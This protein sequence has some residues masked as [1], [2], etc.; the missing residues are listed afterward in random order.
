MYMWPKGTEK[1][2][3][4]V[5]SHVCGQGVRR[6]C[7]CE[8][9]RQSSKMSPASIHQQKTMTAPRGGVQ[10]QRWEGTG[11]VLCWG[12]WHQEAETTLGPPVAHLLNGHLSLRGKGHL[13][14]KQLNTGSQW[15]DGGTPQLEGKALLH[16]ARFWEAEG[17]RNSASGQHREEGALESSLA[18]PSP[19]TA[20]KSTLTPLNNNRKNRYSNHAEDYKKLW[21]RTAKLPMRKTQ[22]EKKCNH[23]SG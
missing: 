16:R 15:R 9:A 7:R 3:S 1:S 10:E 21:K 8:Q 19:F 13:R 4:W 5:R 18:P 23:R 22:Q 17:A 2:R 6:C 11:A 20:R 12:R 14:K